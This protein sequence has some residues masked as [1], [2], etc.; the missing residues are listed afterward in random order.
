MGNY[1]NV[2]MKALGSAEAALLAYSLTRKKYV[3]EMKQMVENAGAA[4]EGDDT[5]A[6]KLK[7][8]AMSASDGVF[9]LTDE[10]IDNYVSL[11]SAAH[12]KYKEAQQESV[13]QASKI[14]GW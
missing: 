7:W 6:F 13:E 4:W 10:S 14:S 1:I 2:D 8:N 12:S 5:S 3:D 9:T 11:L